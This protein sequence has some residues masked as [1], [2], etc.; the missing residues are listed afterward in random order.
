MFGLPQSQTA[1]TG[2][3]DDRG[4]LGL[5]H[6]GFPRKFFDPIK[7]KSIGNFV[8]LGDAS[9]MSRKIDTLLDFVDHLPIHGIHP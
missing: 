8:S 4:L 5:G 7:M 3:D 9:M 1:F 6:G 2:G